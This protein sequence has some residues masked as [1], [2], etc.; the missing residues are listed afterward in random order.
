MCVYCVIYVTMYVPVIMF[1]PAMQPRCTMCPREGPNTLQI[2][3]TN[4]SRQNR[5]TEKTFVNLTTPMQH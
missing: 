1:V 5:Q 3:M 4:A 2:K